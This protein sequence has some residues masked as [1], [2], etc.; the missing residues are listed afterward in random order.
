MQT[1]KD[2]VAWKNTCALGLCS[3]ETQYALQGYAHAR[4]RHFAAVYAGATNTP[5]ADALTPDPPEAWHWFE[6]SL[7]LRNTR[8]GKGYKQWLFAR[9]SPEDVAPT[10]SLDTIQGG[11]TLLMREVVRE[12]LRREYSRRCIL[13]LDA[14]VGP[15]LD[16]ATAPTL[17]DLLA[18][19]D[20]PVDT[21]E[22]REMKSIAEQEADGALD[23]LNRRERI[24][25]LARELGL[26][27]A[28]PA[29]TRI[30]CCGRSMLNT[31]YHQALLGLAGHVRSRYPREHASTL[32]FLTC[33]V[34]QAVRKRIFLWGKSENACAQ[35]F[36]VSGT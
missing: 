34:Y 18:D 24:A 25:L 11:A 33:L 23:T 36:M 4:F 7:R 5:D 13:P 19:P 29:V 12:R 17:R 2:W 30:A 27:L 15:N 1:I 14:P 28:H 26:S 20:D 16:A 8:E 22:E 32:G 21:V 31:A 10:P 3:K 9:A 35:L 6:T